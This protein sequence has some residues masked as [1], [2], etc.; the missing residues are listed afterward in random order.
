MDTDDEPRRAFLDYVPR[1]ERGNIYQQHTPLS[2]LDQITQYEREQN[3]AYKEICE[4]YEDFRKTET[5]TPTDC[6][7][8]VSRILEA[9]HDIWYLALNK[10]AKGTW[11]VPMMETTFKMFCRE[12]LGVTQFPEVNLNYTPDIMMINRAGTIVFIGDVTVSKNV[13]MADS[14]KTTK[15]K[16]LVDY[17]NTMVDINTG[18]KRFEVIHHNFVVRDDLDNLESVLNHFKGNL[19]IL[20]DNYEP[21]R[22]I[23]VTEAANML[24]QVLENI[25]AD[26]GE[27]NRLREHVR[28]SGSR[29]TGIMLDSLLDQD[30]QNV[31]LNDYI[32]KY[33]EHE[34]IDMIKAET[35][36][37]G[38]ASYYDTV[39]EDI[40]NAFKQVLVENEYMMSEIDGVPTKVR[41]PMMHPKSTLKVADNSH[42]M[43]DVTGHFLLRDYIQDLNTSAPSNVRDYI[44]AIMPNILQ[45]NG[46]MKVRDKKLKRRDIKDD[47]QLSAARVGGQYQYKRKQDKTNPILQNFENKVSKGHK[48]SGNL[49]EK[50]PVKCLDNSSHQDFINFIDGSITYYGSLSLK[51][52]VVDDSW[53]AANKYEFD[54]TKHERACYDYVRRT[55]GAQ[56]CHAMSSLFN[57]ITHMSA[58]MGTFDNIYV[59]PN[60]SFIAIMPSNHAPVTS[61]NCDMPFI[62][63]TR[64]VKDKPLHHIEYEYQMTTAKHIYYVTKLCRLNT[65][66]ISCW[67]NAGYRLI[68]SASYLL[69]K[70]SALNSSK[71][72]VIGLL[73]HLILDVHQ[74]VSEYMDLLK[75]IGFMPFADIHLLKHLIK[76]K[77][78]LIMKTQ[79]DVWTFNRLRCFV[80]ELAD[81]DK[82]DASKPMIETYNGIPTSESLGIS[83]KLPSF[84]DLSVRHDAPDEY[85]EELQ[86]LNTSRPKH[87]YGSQFSDTSTHNTVKWNKDFEDEVDEHGEWALSGKGEMPYPFHAKFC[88]SADAVHYSTRVLMTKID[89]DKS[90]IAHRITTGPYTDFMHNNCSLRGCTK[91]PSE[92][93][94]Q[95][96]IHTTSI[97]ACFERYEKDN[98]DDDKARALSIGQS[99][100]HSGDKM[101]FSMSEKDQRGAG[102]PIATPTLSTKA[103]LMLI[104]KPEAE[105]GK[106]MPNNILVQ[107][108][109]KLSEQHQAYKLCMADGIRLGLKNIYQLTE[110][111][112]KYSEND[113]VRKYVPYILSNTMVPEAI[114]KVQLAGLAKLEDRIHLTK[115]IPTSVR[116]DPVLQG[117][118]VNDN[119]HHGVASIIG[120]PQGM[121]NSISTSVH[122]A[123]DYWIATA[124]RQAYPTRKMV[125]R[126][127]VHS[128]DSWVTI[129]CDNIETFK[130]FCLFRTVAKKMFCLKLNEKKLWGG[131]FLGELVSNYN[132]NG[133]VHNSTG[134]VICNGMSNLTYQNWPIDVSNQISTIQQ[135]MRAGGTMGNMIMLS[136]LLRHQITGAYQI[137]GL[138]KDL[139][140]CL[141]IELG[142]YPSGSVYR[143]AVSG[144]HA[145]YSDIHKLLTTSP[146]DDETKKRQDMVRQ[147]ISGTIALSR[148]KTQPFQT[149]TVNGVINVDDYD[150][151]EIPTKG[152]LFSSV[153][154]LMPKSKKMSMAMAVVNRVIQDP[155]FPSDGLAL[156]VT[157]PLTL[158]ESIGHYG[159][160][161]KTKQFELSA[162]R[163]TQ[164]LRK[165]A[166]SQAMQSAGK[167]V[168][169]NDSPPLTINEAIQ[170]LLLTPV[171]TSD[172]SA[173]VESMRT[174]NEVVIACDTIVNT[175]TLEPTKRS[176]GKVINKMPDIEN[177]YKTVAPLKDVLLTI[178]DMRCS[179]NHSAKYRSSKCSPDTLYNDAKDILARFRTFYSYFDPKRAS[180][181]VMQGWLNTIKER[182]WVQ[183]KV[184]TENLSSF[185]EDLYGVSMHRSI[186]FKVRADRTY[187]SKKNMDK[188]TVHDVYTTMVLNNIYPDKINLTH[189]NGMSTAE[190]L[191][192]VDIGNLDTNT[193]YKYGIAQCVL[194]KNKDYLDSVIST[195]KFGYDW[196]QTQTYNRGRY[197]GD[198]SV[199]FMYSDIVCRAKCEMGIISLTV[200]KINMTKILRAMRLMTSRCFSN[201]AYEYDTAWWMSKL[202]GSNKGHYDGSHHYLC[203]YNAYDT[204]VK[205]VKS[206]QSICLYV[207]EHLRMRSYT[208]FMKPVG[209]EFSDNYRIIKARTHEI[210]GKAST[211]RVASVFQDF[212]ILHPKKM[213]M[214]V[215][216]IDGFPISDLIAN[217]VL[218]DVTLNR[219]LSI[220]KDEA[221]DLLSKNIS[222]D[223]KGVLWKLFLNLYHF[224]KHIRQT[225]EKYVFEEQQTIGPIESTVDLV[226]GEFYDIGVKQQDNVESL[227]HV[228][229]DLVSMSIKGSK[230][231]YRP[232]S[233]IREVCSH[234]YRHMDTTMYLDYIFSLLGNRRI[235]KWF[236]EYT[237][238]NVYEIHEKLDTFVFQDY[239][240]TLF[241]FIMANKLDCTETWQEIP[242]HSMRP[243]NRN[244]NNVRRLS[245]LT[246][247]TIAA[248]D[249]NYFLDDEEEERYVSILDTFAD[250]DNSESD[251]DVV[252]HWAMRD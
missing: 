158:A 8:A 114:R 156:I 100:I 103:C 152:E 137:S 243:A 181:L 188:D 18:H 66:T 31:P 211:Y 246:N 128:D 179:T 49:N 17:L 218:E 169:L 52:P 22:D 24:I 55:N 59:P 34:I 214:D 113:N 159:E 36:R 21:Y 131:R 30:I 217:G 170:A 70:S 47:Q 32:P 242:N 27:Y 110:D 102:R 117:Y 41:K 26:R 25:V 168:R 61:N 237:T 191:N 15:Y 104:E 207:D 192:S 167:T 147:I 13:L 112:T 12:Y 97:S 252:E 210:D 225:T 122:C 82:L 160:T 230:K 148:S 75:Y 180:K 123:A 222:M 236:S 69:A 94:N 216:Y 29:D 233:I 64:T 45:I 136:T 42:S 232:K 190:A 73:T 129:C 126:G 205:E 229:K 178:I 20:D 166:S 155:R 157:K 144:V 135:T 127:L 38:G 92:R 10:N 197:E 194:N 143:L 65:R 140:H 76:D 171:T 119:T 87:L 86:V 101:E 173:A 215:T 176:K 3:R 145:H 234:V 182:S 149:M 186:V 105:L 111:Q 162:E 5:I 90:K 141:P 202:W 115:S 51:P 250:E 68:A 153:K 46:M 77:C 99:F 108:K 226:V 142:G 208:S 134:K 204:R 56:L 121:L 124:F 107:G 248:F 106:F 80:R 58:H 235:N 249:D 223:G 57:R 184:S 83:M 16:V 88:F 11:R 14:F 161:A 95:K 221:L 175:C 150:S 239:D 125:V 53:D 154:H 245:R 67:D 33:Q 139:L 177:I 132:L 213:R 96:D 200:N 247:E 7:A 62:F 138:Q 231:L 227:E 85:I 185:L 37:L 183:P 72:K 40:D 151:I 206:D 60:G 79:M 198:W 133:Y 118:V 209:Y 240:P 63:I 74:K 39:P 1:V 71:V 193:L 44:L 220:T 81:I 130:L 195:E 9:R 187:M 238:E 2:R 244:L 196:E 6:Y 212:K 189:Y 98:F 251:D 91:E 50:G 89:A 78:N 43:V 203:W 146:K 84:C 219:Q 54:N 48:R 93:S 35:E 174:E 116:A 28:A 199:V 172:K 241:Q 164:S 23:A 201:M 224:G 228:A 19:Q 109:N 163:Y 165:L 4:L 120:W